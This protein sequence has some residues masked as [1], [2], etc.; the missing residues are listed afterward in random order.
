MLCGAVTYP[1]CVVLALSSPLNPRPTCPPPV[2]LALS[3]FQWE[4]ELD[5]EVVLLSRTVPAGLGCGLSVMMMVLARN[6][7]SFIFIRPGLPGE[8]EPLYGRIWC[9]DDPVPDPGLGTS[10][11]SIMRDALG[12]SMK[13][14]R[15]V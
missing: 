1:S 10:S 2:V 3:F 5:R 11:S 14:A 13:L 6:T 7:S 15:R 12:R 9:F 8:G 4:C